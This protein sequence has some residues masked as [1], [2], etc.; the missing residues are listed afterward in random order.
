MFS[1]LRRG[2]LVVVAAI[3]LFAVGGAAFAAANTTPPS[4]A[5]D[6]TATTVSGFTISN[7]VYVLNTTDPQSIDSVTYTAQSGA[8]SGWP[9][10]LTTIVTRISSTAAEWYVCSDGGGGAAAGTYA[11]TCVTD[12][13]GNGSFFYDGATAGVQLT[14][15]NAVEFDTVLV[16]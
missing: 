7:I 9:A 6:D 5:G 1:F 16:Q 4:S 11:I 14:V 3:A 10:S 15:V 2:P 12:G 8:A 13:T